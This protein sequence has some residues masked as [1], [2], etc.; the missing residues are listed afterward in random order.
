M[1]VPTELGDIIAE[2]GAPTGAIAL[3]YGLVRGAQALEKD[4][5]DHALR[6]ISTFLKG[7]SLISFGEAVKGSVPYI[8]R[9]IFG[10]TIV[11]MRFLERSIAASLATWAIIAIY[12]HV[13]PQAIANGFLGIWKQQFGFAWFSL[14]DS[15]LFKG[16][17]R[18][19]INWRLSRT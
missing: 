9:K 5:N 16:L 15:G 18:I 4:A 8:F 14:A 17:Q 6:S 13:S 19:Q 10:Q 2:L 7:R 12:L 3:A 1:A 11:S